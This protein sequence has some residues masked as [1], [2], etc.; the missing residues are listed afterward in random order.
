MRSDRVKD[1]NLGVSFVD[2]GLAISSAAGEFWSR[3]RRSLGVFAFRRRVSSRSLSFGD[4]P[5]RQEQGTRKSSNQRGRH[6]RSLFFQEGARFQAPEARS[7]SMTRPSHSV[8]HF[9][10]KLEQNQMGRAPVTRVNLAK[11]CVFLAGRPKPSAA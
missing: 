1:E 2:S 4:S 5:E 9:R 7:V 10:Q 3:Q 11:A 6:P 8:G